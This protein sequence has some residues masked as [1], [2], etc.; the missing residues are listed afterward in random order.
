[1]DLDRAA[2]TLLIR[3]PFYGLFLLNLNRYYGNRCETACVCRN[4]INTELCVNKEF[5][6]KLSDDEQLGVLKHELGHILF[7]HITSSEYY[8]DHNHFN[9]AADCEVNSYIPALQKDPYCYPAHW[10]LANNQGTK[11]YYENVPQ[12][13]SPDGGGNGEGEYDPNDSHASWED[14]QDLSDTEKELVE[15]QIDHQ[16]KQTAEHVQK[17]AGNIPGELS[18]YIGNLFKQKPAVFNWKAYFR[19]FLGTA[20]DEQIRKSRKK[21][22]LRF[23]DASG[24]KH[25]RKSNILVAIDTSGSVSNED[26]CDFFSEINHIYKAGALITLIEF[27]YG[28]NKI[29]NYNGKWNGTCAGRGGTEFS[30]PWDYYIKHKRDYNTF[31]LFT[32]GYASTK[33]LRPVPNVVWVITS[34]GDQ[35]NTYPGKTIFIPKS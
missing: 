14:F 17:I 13:D 10:N 25:K 35:N 8:G 32:D 19:R 20:L 21:E 3:E 12:Q 9:I 28:I 7:K 2:K 6:D 31:V 30:E 29:Y 4:G 33:E 34:D 22:S 27:D 1:M 16:A 15:Q 26:L 5:W 11:F 24:I 18:E 23:P